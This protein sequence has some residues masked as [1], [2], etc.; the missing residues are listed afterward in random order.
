[1]LITTG[2]IG[3]AEN[4]NDPTLP[5]NFPLEICKYSL[6]GDGPLNT[7]GDCFDYCP[8]GFVLKIIECTRT[9]CTCCCQPIPFS[10]L[11]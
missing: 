11:L 10:G 3:E 7:G 6:F 9:A 4:S 5:E 1:M 8:F 2:N